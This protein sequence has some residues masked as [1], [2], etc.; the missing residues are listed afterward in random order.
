MT[1]TGSTE[2]T[3]QIINEKVRKKPMLKTQ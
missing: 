3:I 1:I 2:H